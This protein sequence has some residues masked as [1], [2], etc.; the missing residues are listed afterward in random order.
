[1]LW[2]KTTPRRLFQT[3]VWDLLEGLQVLSCLHFC[4]DGRGAII[5]ILSRGLVESHNQET[6]G[7]Y[8]E[9]HQCLMQVTKINQH[10][11]R[12]T[13]IIVKLL[14]Q[15]Q[16]SIVLPTAKQLTC[17]TCIFVPIFPNSQYILAPLVFKSY[18]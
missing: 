17:S 16:P 7:Q 13:V 8:L 2:V 5:N 14:L 12:S 9:S 6:Q 4:R 1:M 11:V 18:F 10:R 3:S 15:K